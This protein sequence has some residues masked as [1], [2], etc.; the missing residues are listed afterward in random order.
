MKTLLAISILIA[1][2]RVYAQSAENLWRARAIEA[3]EKLKIEEPKK[4]RS[5]AESCNAWLE[6]AIS[7]IND[8]K[9]PV[10]LIDKSDKFTSITIPFSEGNG[11]AMVKLTYVNTQGVAATITTSDPWTAS[12]P[13]DGDEK[14]LI[15][16]HGKNCTYTFYRNDLLNPK[17]KKR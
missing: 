14:V 10:K 16:L 2:Q 6:V 11:L 9:A 8:P 5:M 3:S 17:S 1:A 4:K 7:S 12:M 15:E 13:I